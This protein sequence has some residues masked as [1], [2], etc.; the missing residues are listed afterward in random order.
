MGS[1]Y[2]KYQRG[3]TTSTSQ[4]SEIPR[5]S[6][7]KKYQEVRKLPV[8]Y[9]VKWVDATTTGG[10]E[11]MEKSEML[12]A[13]KAKLPVMNTV[14]YLVYEDDYQYSLVSTLGPAESSQ[15]HKIPKCMILSVEKLYG[16]GQEI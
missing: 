7:R 16:T 15:V 10:A 6:S 14:G 5:T 4:K 1:Y 8:I 2:P 9:E 3:K 11:W 13:A 12:A